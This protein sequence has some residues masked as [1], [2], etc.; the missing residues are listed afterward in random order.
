M[1]SGYDTANLYADNTDTKA[2]EDYLVATIDKNSGEVVYQQNDEAKI[3]L[4]LFGHKDPKSAA[5]NIEIVSTYGSCDIPLNGGDRN[6][7]NGL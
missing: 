3:I 7:Q 5:A 1:G 2:V 4:N 6:M